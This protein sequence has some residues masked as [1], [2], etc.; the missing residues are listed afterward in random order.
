MTRGT[1]TTMKLIMLVSAFR[2]SILATQHH[3][4]V[5]WPFCAVLMY[6][7][8]QMYTDFHVWCNNYSILATNVNPVTWRGAVTDWPQCTAS[9]SMAV[10]CNQRLLT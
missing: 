4:R 5:L 7:R 3:A 6:F 10:A 1:G 2:H 9:C 8:V